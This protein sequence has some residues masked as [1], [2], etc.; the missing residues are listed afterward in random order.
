MTVNACS[1]DRANFGLWSTSRTWSRTSPRR[2]QPRGIGSR[3]GL[4]RR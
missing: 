4:P 2:N 1:G 3:A